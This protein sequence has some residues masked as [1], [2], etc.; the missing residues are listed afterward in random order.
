MKIGII[1]KPNAGKSTLFK[2][3]TEKDV[4]IADYPFTTINPN[5]GVAYA[6]KKCVHIE[7]KLEKCDA[8]NSKCING[9]RFIPVNILDVAGLVPDAH[10]GKGMGNQFLSN[11]AEAN[12]LIQVIDASGRTD[13]KGEIAENYNPE[14]EIIF[15]EEEINRWFYS[16]ISSNWQSEMRRLRIKGAKI[17][18]YLEEKYSGLG[19]SRNAVLE[20]IN[21][22]N[23][24][25]TV[26]NWSENELYLFSKKLREKTKPII[27]ACNKMDLSSSEKNF[28]IIKK[29]FSDRILIPVSAQ[30]ELILKTARDS[31]YIDYI[32]GSDNFIIKK[33][34]NQKQSE[35]LDK[36]RDFLKK[37]G[38][39]GVQKVINEAVFNLMDMIVV[40]PVEDENKF[41][42]KNGN[43]LPDA[44]IMKK[45]LKAIDLAYKIHTDLGKNFIRAINVKTGQI[46]GKDYELRDG[47]VIKIIASK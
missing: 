25:K 38:S 29:K 41:S 27:Y 6:S 5:L 17:E 35:V 31:G 24:E 28:E 34:L 4:D 32:P 18:D 45:G 20:A 12:C 1:G 16:I 23:L 11:I 46:I 44:I 36:I 3:L 33:E 9:F 13:E 19:L 22:L 30:Y 39:T 42:D 26:E 2:V 14:R 15:I 10:K 40:Y 43:V 37:Y 8:R 7:L 47:D 21:E